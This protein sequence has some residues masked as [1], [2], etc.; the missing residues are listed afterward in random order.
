MSVQQG[1][2]FTMLPQDMHSSASFFP[3]KIQGLDDCLWLYRVKALGIHQI[4]QEKSKHQELKMTDLSEP[5]LSP[6]VF[7]ASD[8]PVTHSSITLKL[9]GS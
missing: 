9:A 3:P 8:G 1:Y 4:I 2:Y 7:Q 5:E 6:F